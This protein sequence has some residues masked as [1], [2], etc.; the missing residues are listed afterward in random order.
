[1]DKVE[2]LEELTAKAKN[3]PYYQHCLEEVRA[4]E[5]L[6]LKICDSLP[7]M[8]KKA[9]GAYITACEELDHALLRLTKE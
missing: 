4:L 7:E 2:W 8:Q 5:P 1:M 6:F 3:D 9:L